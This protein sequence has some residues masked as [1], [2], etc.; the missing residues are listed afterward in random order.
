VKKAVSGTNVTYSKDGSGAAGADV[1]I[2]VVGEIPYAEM[3]GDTD[4]LHLS[5]EDR[6]A[7]ANVKSAGIPVVVILVSGRVMIVTGEI[8]QADAFIAAWLPGTEGD[9]IADV[10]FGGYNPTGKLSYTWPR[11][12]ADIPINQGDGKA[13]LFPLGYGLSY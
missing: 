7:I 8:E 5:E 12:M 1:G 13:P 3:N 4:D 2:V 11:L 6:A 10:L 9:G